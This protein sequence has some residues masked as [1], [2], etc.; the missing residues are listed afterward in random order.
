MMKGMPEWSELYQR[1]ADLDAERQANEKNRAD[2]AEA[3]RQRET[4]CSDVEDRV[5]AALAKVA[6]RRAREFGESTGA[7]V[8]VDYPAE[9]PIFAQELGHRMSFIGL[10]LGG[11]RVH[12]YS[13]RPHAMLPHVH[14]VHTHQ[15][16]ATRKRLVSIPGCVVVRSGDDGF[17]LLRRDEK[18]RVAE[19]ATIEDVVYRAFEL[20]VDVATAPKS[21]RT[22]R[23]AS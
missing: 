4:W 8:E 10:R 6:Q 1:Y 5:M 12:I 9:K 19:P 7:T 2:A 20:L 21:M 14:L 11:S 13:T 17:E 3:A 18:T 15:S 23:I 16:D 22:P